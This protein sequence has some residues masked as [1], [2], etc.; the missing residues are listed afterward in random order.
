MLIPIL[1]GL[2]KMRPANASAFATGERA[3]RFAY[4]HIGAS[5]AIAVIYI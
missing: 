1:M 5:V 3:K 2:P 4:G